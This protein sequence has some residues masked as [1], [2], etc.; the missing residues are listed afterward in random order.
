[1][2]KYLPLIVLLFLASCQQT[3]DLT[4]IVKPA[5][6]PAPLDEATII[7]GLKEALQVGIKNAVSFV[8]KSDGYLK[9]PKIALPLPPQLKDWADKLRSIGLGSQVDEFILSMNRAAE[10][11]AAKAVDIFL[12]AISK[13][14]VEDANNILKGSENAATAFFEKVTR[15]SL[16]GVF[17]PVIKQAMDE[18]GITKLYKTLID[19]YNSIPLVQKVNFDLAD[20]VNNKALDGLYYMLAQEEAKIRKDPAARVTDLLKKVFGS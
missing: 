9:S 11:A 3:G 15:K 7:S 10:K 20:Y 4:S 16:Y 19:K 1:M 6:K 5:A 12:D 14:T 17:A 18:V 13:M 2:K 8:S